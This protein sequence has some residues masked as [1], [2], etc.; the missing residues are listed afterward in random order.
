MPMSTTSATSPSSAFS[1]GRLESRILP[2][3]SVASAGRISSPVDMTA[4]TGRRRTRGR[5]TPTDASTPR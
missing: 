4:A 1:I 5:A 3:T 2:G